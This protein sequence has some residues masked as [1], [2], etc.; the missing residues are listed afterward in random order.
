MRLD[1][2][3]SG[4]ENVK[5]ITFETRVGGCFFQFKPLKS[6][7]GE[8]TIPRAKRGSVENENSKATGVLRVVDGNSR[9]TPPW[10]PVGTVIMAYALVENSPYTTTYAL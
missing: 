3:L 9:K 6:H 8:H 7:S 2:N 5:K 4:M 1:N 10:P